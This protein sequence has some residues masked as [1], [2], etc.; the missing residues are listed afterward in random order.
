[1]YCRAFFGLQL[2]FADKV[3]QVSGVPLERALLDY[4]NFYVRFGLGRDFNPLNPTWREYLAG[5]RTH[6]ALDWTYRFYSREPE[7]R[8]APVT[9]LSYGCFSYSRL[10]ETQVH[11]HFRNLETDGRSPLAFDRLD[12]RLEELTGLFRQLKGSQPLS[13]VLGASWLYN[14]PAYRRLF[15]A[16]YT[17]SPRALE[18]RFR[19]MSLWGQFLDRNHQVKPDMRLEFRRRFEGATSLNGLNACFPLPVLAV[20]AALPDF[21]EFYRIS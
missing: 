2:E 7:L 17:A 8:T 4:T 3:R 9:T 19:S 6:D 5:L 20:Q 21:L 18:N 10:N 11:L 16:S 15:P 14:L 12:Q 1:M 13:K